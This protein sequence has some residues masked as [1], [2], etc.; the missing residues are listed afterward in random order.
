MK[1]T[2]YL[3]IGF[4]LLFATSS[5]SSQEITS[6]NTNLQT[7]SVSIKCTPDLY[8]LT[9]KWA[10]EFSSL[11]P[12]VKINV[13]EADFGST[14][15]GT[16]GSLGFISGKATSAISNESNWK[17]VVG[18]DVVVAIMNTEN[19]FS[20]EVNKRGI[21]QE[22]LAQMLINPQK[23]N[24]GAMLVNS[25]AEPVHIYIVNDET[26]K[27]SLA[28]F[29]NKSS[30]EFTGITV[31]NR[32]EVISAIQKDPY[33][34]G[35]CAL[36]NIMNES[37]QD[38]AGNM[39][40]LPIDKNRNGTLDYMENIYTDLNTFQR[41]V[42]IGKYPKS[43]VSNV[44]AVSSAQPANENE[45]E[46]LKW[47]ISEGQQYMNANGYCELVGSESQA[48][49]DK[50]TIASVNVS[51]VK[52]ASQAGTVLLILAFVLVAGLVI[53]A[54]V[55]NYRKQKNIAPDFNVS[56]TG[57][58]EDTVILPNG[59]YFDKS[60]TWSFMEKDGNITVGVDDFLQHITGPVTR[61]EMKS[62]GETIRKGDVLFSIIQ[63][64]KQLNI[65][66]P[67]SGIIKKQNVNL[68]SDSSVI[69]SSPYE[70]GWVYRIE[71][72]NW[73]KEVQLMD[74]SEKYRRWLG[75]EFIRLKE[76]MTAILRPESLESAHVVLQDGGELKEGVLGDFG[77][78]VWEDF[79]TNFLDTF[80]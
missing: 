4:L 25:L 66:A 38:L 46:F 57:F 69:N 68:L 26:V 73:I 28:K 60:H 17:M 71:P 67:F 49:L 32:D 65:Y 34:I 2:F 30:I 15:F 11:N 18:R 52:D 55:R 79:Q 20:A 35:F 54:V 22:Q 63:F 42:W 47:V 36:V 41:G 27:A 12:E 58:S 1:A 39:T 37:D 51:P 64:G 8:E 59:L 76:F 10:S 3:I 43:L 33:A 14:G 7:G 9:S 23:R 31:S 75:A 77:P 62:P 45:L 61:I 16:G 5:I 40:L 80:K 13:S 21:A 74:L 6:K 53:T 48:Q 70:A 50:L 19:P 44:Y 78:K 24:W 72:S 29:I 56:Q